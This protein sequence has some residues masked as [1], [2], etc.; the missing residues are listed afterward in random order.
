M[1][2]PMQQHG[3]TMGRDPWLV[4]A[5]ALGLALST[6]AA[7]AKDCRRETPLPT[8]VHLIAPGPEVP[9]AVARFAGAWVGTLQRDGGPPPMLVYLG[10][11]AASR[12]GEP[13]RPGTL[14]PVVLVAA[15]SHRHRMRLPDPLHDGA[16]WQ[17][18]G[19][20][21]ERHFGFPVR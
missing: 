9:E 14:P 5:V 16:G 1:N 19:A 15:L 17:S 10:A 21:A 8:D 11:G 6:Q 3:F 2:E 4:M 12:P 13:V 7:A 18:R 20:A